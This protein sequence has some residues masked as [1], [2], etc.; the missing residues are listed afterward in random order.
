MRPPLRFF[1]RFGWLQAALGTAAFILVLQLLPS[2]WAGI[3]S[4]RDVRNWPR[5]IRYAENGGP[6]A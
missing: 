1:A 3:L 4:M 2:F 5:T 6:N